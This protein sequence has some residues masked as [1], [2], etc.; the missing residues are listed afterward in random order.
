M[1]DRIR[2]LAG[3]C[4]VRYETDAEI[5]EQRGSVVTVVKPDNTVLVHD[6]GGYR[7]VAWLTRADA[8]TC[9]RGAPPTVLAQ[10]DDRLLQVTAHDEYGFERYPASPAGEA[11]GRCPD[12][13]GALIRADGT[14]RC[15]GCEERHKVPTDAVVLEETCECGLPRMRVERG[16]SFEPCVDRACEPLPV[17][18]RERF[19]RAWDCPDCG[20]DLRILERAGLIAG[21]EGYPDCDAGFSIPAGTVDGFCDC[22]LPIFETP[23]GRRC[24][25]ATCQGAG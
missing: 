25:D 6:V 23:T 9:S 5:R 19:D 11:V 22:G 15:L 16:K 1:P 12:C 18:V 17:A 4:T 2:V 20:G 13:D 3:D 14:V 24:L 7:P 21:C 10:G 8:V